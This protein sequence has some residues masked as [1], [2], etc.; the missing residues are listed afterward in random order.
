MRFT[1]RFVDWRL[2]S[3]VFR[4]RGDFFNIFFIY[5]FK[6][7]SQVS[8]FIMNAFFKLY[9]THRTRDYCSVIVGF[10]S[11]LVC[12]S[13]CT[14]TKP[15]TYFKAITRDTTISEIAAQPKMLAIKEG[16]VLTITISSLNATEDAIYNPRPNSVNSDPVSVGANA[17]FQVGADGNIF[18]HNLGKVKVL[19]LT[20]QQ[21]KELLEKQLLPYL[22]DPLVTVQFANHHVIVL[23]EITK[24]Q[25]FPI[26]GEQL[27]ILDLLANS[28]ITTQVTKL[29]SV[30][31]IRENNNQKEF[32]H[33]NLEDHSIFS[34]PYYYLQPN[35]VVVLAQDEKILQQ[36]LRKEGYRQYASIIFQAISVAIIIYQ[37][38]FRN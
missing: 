5:F 36:Q 34:S 9:A 20:R 4:L 1:W 24:P 7:L 37:A 10:L 3:T 29:S 30:L 21:L 15:S 8:F 14:M 25:Q 17:G 26:S 22:K 18:V 23:G 35:D 27:T 16:D 13:S 31:V 38:F 2:F 11:L 6:I 32:R 28:G 19:G 12:A 33:V